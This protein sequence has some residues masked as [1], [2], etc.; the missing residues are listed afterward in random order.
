MASEL[1]WVGA[2]VQA[3]AHTTSTS[4]QSL[5]LITLSSLPGSTTLKAL[6]PSFPSQCLGYPKKMQTNYKQ[7]LARIILRSLARKKLRFRK[8]L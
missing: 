4:S 1:D 7:N 8:F 2:G 3:Q 6:R 5:R